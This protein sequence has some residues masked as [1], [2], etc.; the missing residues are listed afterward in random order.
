MVEEIEQFPVGIYSVQISRI[1]KT[2]FVYGIEA[3]MSMEYIMPNLRIVALTEMVD[4]ETLE[5]WLVQ[6]MELEEDHF[7]AR[8]HQQV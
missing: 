3:I 4:H 2:N 7:L 8:F 5:E 6:I 1:R